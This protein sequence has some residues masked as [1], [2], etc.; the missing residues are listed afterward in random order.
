MLYICNNA[1]TWNSACHIETQMTLKATIQEYR[2][3]QLV[4]PFPNWLAV[5]GLIT[6]TFQAVE[7]LIN[8]NFIIHL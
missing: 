8:H 2:I 3:Q 1:I 7:Y 4:I 6:H 5:C